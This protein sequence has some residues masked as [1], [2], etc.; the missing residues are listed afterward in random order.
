MTRSLRKNPTGFLALLNFAWCDSLVH[1][2]LIWPAFNT[3]FLLPAGQKTEIKWLNWYAVD[4]LT[5]AQEVRL[6]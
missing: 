5:S 1:F 2:Q 3:G 6:L 4:L